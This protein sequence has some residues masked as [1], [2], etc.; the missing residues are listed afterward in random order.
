MNQE[1]FKTQ[2]ARR[3]VI[4]LAGMILSG[5]TLVSLIASCLTYAESFQDCGPFL[6]MVFAVIVTFGV[7]GAF[8]LLV[9]GMSKAYEGYEMLVAVVGASG[10]LFVMGANFIVHSHVARG[11]GVTG[12]EMAWRN[13]VGLIVPFLT[14]GLFVLLGFISPEAKQR[15]QLRKMHSIGQMRA[16][17]YKQEYL[18][19]P[20]LDNELAQMRP[21]IAREVRGY[22]AS[23]LPNTAHA[24]DEAY[25]SPSRRPIQGFNP[26]FN[27]PLNPEDSGPIVEHLRQTYFANPNTTGR[28]K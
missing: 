27:R 23:T 2:R 25:P 4:L 28:L 26:G 5:L 13:Y 8:V 9:H 24:Q 19:S 11:M 17:D 10:L 1:Q 3:T 15:R 22:I 21:L 14:I 12:F 7:E 18:D 6:A 20:E 16:L